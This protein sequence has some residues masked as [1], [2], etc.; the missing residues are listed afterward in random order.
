LKRLRDSVARFDKFNREY[1][2]YKRYRARLL[3]S[4]GQ[5][6]SVSALLDQRFTTAFIHKLIEE[7]GKL[8]ID[9]QDDEDGFDRE[10]LEGDLTRYGQL[11]KEA[12]AVFVQIEED[13]NM[14][15]TGEESNGESVREQFNT[16]RS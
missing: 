15:G 10:M 13:E 4:K 2:D 9:S 3:K 5:Q 8:Q 6:Y 11:H 16:V 14:M 1:S 12:E 7:Q